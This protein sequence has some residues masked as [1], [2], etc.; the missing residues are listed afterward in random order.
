MGAVAGCPR[1]LRPRAQSAAAQS[2]G[3]PRGAPHV[4][5]HP[6]LQ[7]TATATATARGPLAAAAEHP[8]DP[9]PACPVPRGA[10]AE[11]RPMLQGTGGPGAGQGHWADPTE[12][13]G[14]WQHPRGHRVVRRRLN[15]KTQN[16][17]RPPEANQH[18]VTQA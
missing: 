16:T 18:G 10:A 8:A 14:G 13:A 2:A 6:L 4:A 7:P 17:A 11:D 1:L 15:E 12:A 9:R 3:A 5:A